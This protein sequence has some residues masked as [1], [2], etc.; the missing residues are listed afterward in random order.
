MTGPARIA[1]WNSK[2]GVAKSTTCFHVA[3]AMAERHLR[4]LVVDWDPLGSLSV[5]MH[6]AGH[7]L[8]SPLMDYIAGTKRV[9]ECIYTYKR[10]DGRLCFVPINKDFIR[11]FYRWV[12]EVYNRTIGFEFFPY[13]NR[14]L[15][16]KY[17]TDHFDVVLLDGEPGACWSQHNLFYA[18]DYVV[19]PEVPDFTSLHGL[20]YSIDILL[21]VAKEVVIPPKIL[22]VLPVMLRKRQTQHEQESLKEIMSICAENRIPFFPKSRIFETVRYKDACAQCEPVWLYDPSYEERDAYKVVADTIIKLISL[23]KERY[24]NA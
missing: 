11:L 24:T 18:C 5:F 23:D 19:I 15:D 10:Y 21:R 9:E 16:E 12:N 3:C 7:K 6:P 17:I 20:V 13:L 22:F 2:G 14:F 4:V 1:V 8:G